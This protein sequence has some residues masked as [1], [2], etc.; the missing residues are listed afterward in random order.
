MIKVLAVM[1]STGG[2]G[3]ET[4]MAAMAPLMIEHGVELDVAYFHERDGVKDQFLEAGIR[5]HHVLPGRSRL[6]TVWRLRRL[7]KEVQPDLVHTMV[8]EADI[9]GRTAAF[10]AR[11]P[12]MSSIINEMYGPDQLAS[13]PHAWKL[14]V[15]QSADIATAALRP[16]VPRHHPHSRGRDGSPS[17]NTTVEDP[18]DLSRP[19][20][21]SARP[22][23]PGS[24][25]A[26]AQRSRD[27]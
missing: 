21:C 20:S 13:V 4:S 5:L 1:D 6:V 16:S 15:A 24:T 26:R 2:G 18:S 17:S 3:A 22:S 9:I 11:V 8:F 25:Q 7:I 12:V 27:L 10:I 19:R 14:R 23:L